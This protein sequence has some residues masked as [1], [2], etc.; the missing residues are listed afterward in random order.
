MGGANS[1]G[2]LASAEL[3]DPVTGTWSDTGAMKVPRVFH[4]ATLLRSGKVLV[5]GGINGSTRLNSAEVYDPATGT[6]ASAGRIGVGR[7]LHTATRLLDGSAVNS[8]RPRLP[9][10][11]TWQVACFIILAPIPL[12]TPV[13]FLRH[14]TATPLL[15]CG[16]AGCCSRAVL[17]TLFSPVLSYMIRRV[18]SGARPA[19]CTTRTHRTRPHYCITV[20]SWWFPAPMK[21][22]RNRSWNS[23]IRAM[24]L[25][26]KVQYQHRARRTHHDSPKRWVGASSR[27]PWSFWD[28]R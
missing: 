20:L 26:E 5:T 22:I 8:G 9:R 15:A 19:A 16:M 6:W 3:Y 10:I 21:K 24:G 23:I 1:A 14:G 4:T 7:Y 2:D 12:A 11:P 18:V 28:S 17:G 13:V 27:W 25:G